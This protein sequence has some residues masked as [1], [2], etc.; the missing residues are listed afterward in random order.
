MKKKLLSLLSALLFVLATSSVAMAQTGTLSG[1]VTDQRSGETIPGVNI[2]V[3]E[4]ERGAAS[5][6]DGNY[7]IANIPYGTYNLRITA[8]GYRNLTR[9]VEI[10]Q[11][12]TELNIELR[13]DLVG[14]DEI[15]VTG[16]GTGVERS[17][18][19]TTVGVVSAR[20]LEATPSVQ[21]DQILQAN[22]PNSQ[23][24]LS[25]GQPGTASL[26][27][28]RGVVSALTSTTPVVYIDGVRV[29]NT[30]GQALNTGT[31][32]A[33]S[34]ALADI[35][36][37]NIERIE[38]IKGGAA[39]T[40]FGSDA[41][42][43]V[44]QIFTKQG[45]QGRTQFQFE[46]SIGA[47]TGTRDFL[48]YGETGDILYDTGLLQEYRLSASGGT[49]DYTYSFSGSMRGDEGFMPNNNQVRHNLRAT[50]SARVIDN[51]RYRGS[52]GFTSNE[53]SRDY[54]A[55][56][57]ASAFGELESGLGRDPSDNSMVDFGATRDFVRGFV[58]EV[59]ITEDVKRF[60]TSHTL[61]FNLRP[62]LT[63]KAVVGLDY[64]S[65]KQDFSETNAFLIARGF[66][67]AGT[68]DQ[69]F[70]SQTS[71]DFLGLTL[72]A[73]A[74]YEIDFG[75]FSSITNV[76]GQL[77]RNDDRQYRLTGSD[78]PDGS[79]NIGNAAENT[80]TNFRRTVINY[81]A[82]VLE[83]F[84]YLDRY[85]IELGLRVDDNTAFGEEVAAQ[86]YPKV[87]LIYN[88]SSE[89]FF[90]EAIS[91]DFIS[92]LRLRANYGTAGNFP[93]PFSNEVLASLN[94]FFGAATIEFG[95]PG[96]V[97]LKPERT[98]TYEI[99]ADISF[100]NDRINFEV[101]Y[102][103][104]ETTDALFSAP[105]APSFGLGTAL[106]N[107]GTIENKGWEISGNFNVISTRD[108][109]VSLRASLN[110][111]D[112]KVVDNGD[113]AP[114]AVGG[115]AFLGSF[116]DEGFPVG[117]LRGNQPTFAAD[118][119]LESV[120]PNANLG[121]PIP[122]VFGNVGINANYRNWAFNVTADYQVG[123]QGVN[124][125]E[126]LRF[127]GG[128]QDDRIPEPS[129]GASFFDLAGVW[130]ED[131]D[132]FKV[133]LISLSYNVPTRIIGDTFRRV[134]V[135]ASVTNPLNFTSANFDPEVTGAGISSGQGGVGVG[136]F[137]FG[138]ISPPR[139]FVGRVTIDF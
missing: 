18:L 82:Y 72:E 75:D 92:T 112:N 7:T 45:V 121:S 106:Q 40:Q 1:T 33:V 53:F 17:R 84:G 117:Y 114:F 3:Q 90:Q 2:F 103:E 134:S 77:F 86:W 69:G 46:T 93:T 5:D 96:D 71:R 133:R 8:V 116:I 85:F 44:I 68:N 101:S 66:E 109:S 129:L 47:T 110:T 16:Q 27:R 35:P 19:S 98:E 62:G 58:D 14:L 9:Q 34:S 42:N 26:I 83:N 108:A 39:T 123:A 57:A 29:D 10:N 11:A 64:R 12:S 137:G 124:V 59:D 128:Y 15:V 113:S 73:S 125:D 81:G 79:T 122:D 118:G 74:R 131:T 102:Y 94:P 41:A 32:G 78:I 22:L 51:I 115:F 6:I 139:Q 126:V 135:G 43:G 54:N 120:E 60:Q 48:R 30:S 104:A 138:T 76:G 127:F 70:I 65:S 24:R 23:V 55:N 100:Y 87:G 25:S 21:L 105:F 52:F 28:G 20:Q 107:L 56:T 38:V 50:L 31:G 67:P 63:A 36:M 80:G 130:V 132:F 99:G 95:T 4:L 91:E 13:E 49:S 111:L 97:T 119:T 89:P 136:G 61:D 88:L 37:E